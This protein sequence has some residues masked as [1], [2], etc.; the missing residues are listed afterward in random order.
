MSD[1]PLIQADRAVPPPAATTTNGG[2]GRRLRLL[3]RTDRV[4]ITLMVLVPLL[5]VTGLVWL[6][7]VAT[8]LL[9][10]TNWDGIGP[11][12]EIEWVGAKNYDDVVN[13]YPP[14]VP[15]VQNNLLWLAALFVVA[16]PFGMFLAVLLD[17][18]IRGSRFYQTALYLPVVLS[19]ALIGF[20]WQL[21]Y[22]RDQGL[23]NGVFGGETDWYGDPDVN[24][25]AVLVAAGWRHV[26]Y[27][28]LLYL[29]GLKG[30]DPSLREAAAVDGSSETST[31]FRVVFPVLRPINIIVLV[32]TVIESLRAFDLVWVINKGRN[33]L[34][35]IS[36]LVTQNVVGEASRIGF[37][38]AL[39]TIMLA[40]SLVFI[41]IY[42]WTVMREDKR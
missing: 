34:E 6:P 16:T 41:T 28:M 4:V 18:E 12:S 8:V 21:I 33:G 15:A 3:S 30:V 25:W 36:A 26:G 29:A 42:L 17:K 37:G 38:S 13:I 40:V 7:A 2:R 11:I 32:V 10:G 5:L 22:S 39:A 9:S 14:F 20:V 19:L 31:F 23:L 24:I 35:L 27:I 1:L